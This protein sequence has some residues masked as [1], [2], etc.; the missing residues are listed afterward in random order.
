MPRGDHATARLHREWLRGVV[1]ATGIR[2]TTL[3][4]QIRV[5]PSTLTRP[6]KEGDQGTSTLHAST[7][8]K[9]AAAT[10]IAPP[11][12]SVPTPRRIVRLGMAEEAVPYQPNG[13]HGLAG[14]VEAMVAGRN[15]VVA[16]ELRT[17]ALEGAGFLPGDIVMLDLNAAARSGDVVCA[18]VYDWHGRTAE[19]VW[20]L[21]DPPVLIGAARD[22][23]AQPKS[24]IV[25]NDRVLIKGVV[26]GMVRPAN[27]VAMAP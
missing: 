1:K 23:A 3:A 25:D 26:K 24:L 7:I 17:R 16:W 13:N 11:G 9:I 12:A 20:R 5:A 18:Q 27:V 2:P 14:A 8:D 10:G 6:L 22:L 21:Y 4:K 19:T 15:G